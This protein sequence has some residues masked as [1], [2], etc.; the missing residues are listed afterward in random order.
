VYATVSAEKSEIV[1]RVGATPIDYLST[2][3][4]E[5]VAAATGGK[6]FDVVYDTMGGETQRRGNSSPSWP[7][8]VSDWAK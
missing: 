5:Y 1:R 7:T 2:A 8:P 4:E 6:G 3:V